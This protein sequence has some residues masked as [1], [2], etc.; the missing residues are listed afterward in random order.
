MTAKELELRATI[1]FVERDS[2]RP[3]QHLDHEAF[4]AQVQELKP[5][6]SSGEV[7]AAITELRTKGGYV[8]VDGEKV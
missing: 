3:G 2:R 7:G 6:F 1:V 5:Q 4:A 8:R